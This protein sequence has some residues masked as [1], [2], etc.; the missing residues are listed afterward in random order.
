MACSA[1]AASRWMWVPA[2][3]AIQPV[4]AA[5]R[6]RLN[7][8]L[9]DNTSRIVVA[10]QVVADAINRAGTTAPEEIRAA[11]RATSIPGEQTI[12]PWRGVRFDESGQNVECTPVIQQFIGG[13]YQTVYPFAVAA[14]PAIW[15]VSGPA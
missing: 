8:D 6:A 14:K 1:A 3:P 7:T 9:N 2:G 10:L 4:N 13:S 12:M 11:L 15:G 5:I